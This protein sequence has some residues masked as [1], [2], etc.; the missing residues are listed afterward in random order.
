MPAVGD[1][2]ERYRVEALLG[3]GGMGQVYR[4]YDPVL[5][6]RV[7]LKV[8]LASHAQ[9][10]SGAGPSLADRLLREARAVAALRHPNIVSV[11]DVGEAGGEPYIVMEYVEGATLR[12]VLANESPLLEEKIAWLAQIAGALACA[13]ASGVVHRDIKPENVI[14]RSDRVAQVLD[15]GVAKHF[16]AAV[17]A[18]AP[19][20]DGRDSVA[21][22]AGRIVG[23]PRYMSPEQI[24]GD[25][26]DARSDQFSWAVLSYEVLAGV[27]PWATVELAGV[28]GEIQRV[29]PKPLG[30]VCPEAPLVV[31][32]LIWKALA[33]DPAGRFGAMTEIVAALAPYAG[34]GPGRAVSVQQ[35]PRASAHISSTRASIAVLPFLDMSE[36]RDQEHLCEGIAEEILNALA[37]VQGLRVAARSSSFQWKSRSAD[38][39]TV[40]ARLGV[41]VVLEG[42][43]RKSGGLLRVTV[44]LVEVDSGYQKWSHRFDGVVADV[45]AVQDEIAAAVAKLLR[46][47]LSSSAQHALHRPSTT[48]EAYEHFLRG[49]KLLRD[50]DK[51]AVSAA[52]RALERA[53]ELDPSYAPAHAA[54]AQAHAFA[55]EWYGGGKAAEDAA[56]SASRKAVEYGQDLAEAHVARAAVFAMRRDYEGA[57]REYEDA[58]RRAPESFD[59]LYRYARVCFQTGKNER[60]VELFRRAAEVQMEDFQSLVLAAAPLRRLGRHDEANASAREGLRRAERALE[61]DPANSRALSLGA[62]AWLDV[63]DR[64]HALEWCRRGLEVAPHDLG[65]AY[66]AA[67]LY[68]KLRETGSALDCLEASVARGLGRREWL[69]RDP[70]WDSMRS[71]PRFLAILAKLA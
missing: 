67:C 69:E 23:T 56:S 1:T 17:D 42:A 66:N 21:T 22:L 51:E 18:E 7:A 11:Y 71:E 3:Q 30:E 2:F 41:D 13:H 5:R 49:R 26:V 34:D 12:A 19:T 32:Q 63:G 62:C 9:A 61:I 39:R 33:K 15:F 27:S 52:A 31:Q 53:I 46:G 54:L 64:D 47:T 50:Q 65:V 43:V 45:F 14:V 6:R 44:Q 29:H 8:L 57:E 20:F 36:A 28:A 16:D 60:A 70:D 40:G 48:P 59:A 10:R 38:A 35:G 58:L 68:A 24:R 37:Q 4:A 25:E 55:A